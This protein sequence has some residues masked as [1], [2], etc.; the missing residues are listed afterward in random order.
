[1]RNPVIIVTL[2]HLCVLPAFS[3]SSPPFFSLEFLEINAQAQSKSLGDVG[4]VSPLN[5]QHSASQQNPALLIRDFRQ[6]DVNL[7]YM[8]W[9]RLNGAT[10]YFL[11]V[12]GLCNFTDKH[13]FGLNIKYLSDGQ[14]KIPA[15]GARSDY[16]VSMSYAYKF[17]RHWSAGVTY[18]LIR[19]DILSSDGS[20]GVSSSALD[21]GVHYQNVK[22]LLNGKYVNWNIGLSLTNLGPQVNLEPL[23][24][25]VNVFN[26]LPTT[27]KTGLMVGLQQK[28]GQQ[29]SFS[30]NIAYQLDKRLVPVPTEIDRNNDGIHD[31]LTWGAGRAMW[32]S[33]TDA[34]NGFMGEL[35]ELIHRVGIEYRIDDHNYNLALALRFGYQQATDPRYL[36]KNISAGLSIHLRTFYI[37]V[38][39]VNSLNQQ[40]KI[41]ENTVLFSVGSRRLLVESAGEAQDKTLTLL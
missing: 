10:H 11:E 20:I 22:T 7:K 32:R 1:M 9:V 14:L 4:V 31:Y 30:W 23:Y 8:P 36:R 3:Q 21:L 6:I 29:Y 34:S 16:V 26:Y 27:L 2:L 15:S 24:P 33:L 5:N 13:A 39:Y 38:S 28:K 12:G 17:A 19:N 18:K 35:G 40:Q 41:Y 37:D 25:I